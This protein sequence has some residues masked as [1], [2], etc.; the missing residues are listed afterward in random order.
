MQTTPKRINAHAAT[1]IRHLG[2]DPSSAIWRKL[3]KVTDF[4]PETYNCLLNV[5]VQQI[6]CGGEIV[7][8]WVIW[9]DS[10]AS[11]VEAEFHCLW[12]DSQGHLRDITP[13]VDGEKRIC[14]VPDPTRESRM[15]MT[16]YPAVTH[17]FDNVRM[18]GDELVNPVQPK[19]I[20]L[21]RDKLLRYFK[22]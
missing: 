11:F 5:M 10:A 8:G 12:K 20:V 14:F 18:V 3:T 16:R 17:T 6:F 21:T 22:S 19:S 7:F 1:F 13:R 15:D 4:V 9:Q 2:L